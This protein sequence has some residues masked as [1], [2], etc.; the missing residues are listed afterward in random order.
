MKDVEKIKELL[1]EHK[2]ILSE[3]F[4]VKEIGLFGSY[5]RGDQRA[6]SDLDLLVE[7]EETISLLKFVALERYLSELLGV[8]VDLVMKSALRPRIGQRILNEVVYPYSS[9]V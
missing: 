5:V 4:K 9:P 8:K 6:A 7:F 2:K 1:G 3:N